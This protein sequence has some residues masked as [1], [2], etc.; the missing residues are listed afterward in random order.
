MF[1]KQSRLH[2][3][4]SLLRSASLS[5]VICILFTASGS[6]QFMPTDDAYVS[7]YQPKINYGAAQF[8]IVNGVIN[9]AFVQFDL[10]SLPAGYTSANVA[11]ATLR[12]YVNTVS[13]P[14]TFNVNYVLGSWSEKGITGRTVPAIGATVVSGVVVSAGMTGKF[15]VI[16]ITPA[17]DAWLD[18]IVT[19]DGLAFVGDSAIDVVFTSKE[20]TAASH[21]PELDIIFNANGLQGT[22]GPQG[23][24]G[25]QGPAGPQGPQGYVGITG[26]QGP[27][28]PAGI[29]NRGT[30]V[31]TTAY[32]INDG[33]SYNGAPLGSR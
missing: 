4:S 15:L 9:N 18:G 23:P 31:P 27:P 1:P 29:T 21:P 16:D 3:A 28:G 5:F 22:P 11:K 14:G 19:N 20:N 26:P 13:A 12:L 24:Q 7:N 10:S 17:L 2:S 33:V 30:W 8:L 6:S 32:L 25:L